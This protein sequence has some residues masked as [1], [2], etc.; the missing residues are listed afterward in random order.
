MA[1]TLKIDDGAEFDSQKYGERLINHLS[2]D[3]VETE[4]EQRS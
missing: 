3:L 2:K 1:R 4:N